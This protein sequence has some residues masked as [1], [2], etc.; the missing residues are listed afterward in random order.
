MPDIDFYF[1][2]LWKWKIGMKEIESPKRIPDFEIMK[3]TQWSIDFEELMRNRLIMGGIRYGL[4][5]SP[6]KSKYDRMNS[7]IERAKL[8]KETGNIE[9]LAD[10]ANL[11]LC[12]FVEGDHPNRRFAA[13]D[14]GIHT[15]KI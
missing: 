5:N 1:D 9:I 12:E 8:Y 4:L 15:Q 3:K 14:D 10:I 2:N 11:A 7:I 6:G 13:S